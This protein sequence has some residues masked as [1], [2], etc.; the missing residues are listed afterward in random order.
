M[1]YYAYNGV[2]T[3]KPQLEILRNTVSAL[4]TEE[5]FQTFV[6]A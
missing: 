5:Q 2:E 6:I 3:W 4:I 1:Y